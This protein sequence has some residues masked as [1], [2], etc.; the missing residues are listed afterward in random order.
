[1]LARAIKADP[2]IQGLAMIML[3]SRGRRGDAARA[4]DEGFAAYLTKPVKPSVLQR[5]LA[6]VL[7]P[8]A[9]QNRPG[10]R[11]LITAYTLDARQADRTQ[12]SAVLE[13]TTS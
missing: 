2:A 13:E 5:C 3:S 6:A 7:A 9:D 12:P 10:P 4:A 1:M 8:T 11:P